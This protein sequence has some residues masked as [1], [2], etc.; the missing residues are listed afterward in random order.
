MKTILTGAA[1][2]LL[3]I[4]S[5]PQ[6]AQTTKDGWISLFDGKSFDGWKASEHPGTFTIADGM[7]VVHGDRAHL[8]Y[9]GPVKNHDFKNFEF[10][11]QVMTTPG[12]NSGMFIH[13]AY[14]E[15]GWPSKGYEIQ[16]NATHTDWRKTSSI[17]AVQDIKEAPHK[18]NE[19]FTQHIIVNG[20]KITVKVNDKVINEYTVGEGGRLSSGTFA[21]QGHD[22]QSIVY[23]K[24]VMVKPLPD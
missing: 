5:T 6:K 9:M 20:K 1:V 4:C 7:I 19:W 8:F 18:D 24:D 13:T 22:P 12:S 16:V 11:A 23:Y 3:L 10:K 14:Q 2:I 15:E 17:Y 21:L